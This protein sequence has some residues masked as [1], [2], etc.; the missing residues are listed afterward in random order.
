M[1]VIRVW[2]S[3][4]S[5]KVTNTWDTDTRKVDKPF[6]SFD[7]EHYS[8]YPNRPNADLLHLTHFIENL[9]KYG[10]PSHNLPL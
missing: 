1:Y 5:R 2:S 3:S 10:N 4:P 6:I 8:A 7:N 9:S